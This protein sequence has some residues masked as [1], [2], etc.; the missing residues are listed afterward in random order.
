MCYV[1][2][3]PFSTWLAAATNATVIRSTGFKHQRY[4]IY[5]AAAVIAATAE[6]PLLLWALLLPLP[7]PLCGDL[8][9]NI[10]C[11]EYCICKHHCYCYYNHCHNW[12]ALAAACRHY[13]C[14]EN[15]RKSTMLP[16][17]FHFASAM[18]MVRAT[19]KA[20]TLMMATM[21]AMIYH[22]LLYDSNVTMVAII[23]FSFFS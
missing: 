19:A 11:C 10:Y 16:F 3:L 1:V 7:S 12:D 17:L 20:M 2:L 22:H 8:F 21:T 5:N 6:L 9:Q 15:R 4:S 18:M 23:Y 13:H 14:G